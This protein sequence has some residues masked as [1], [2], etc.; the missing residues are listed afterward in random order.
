M[1][2]SSENIFVR[3]RIPSNKNWHTKLT[4]YYSRQ[5]VR[6]NMEIVVA[7]W[8]A[9]VQEILTTL[10]KGWKSSSLTKSNLPLRL[11]SFEWLSCHWSLAYIYP[12]QLR[13]ANLLQWGDWGLNMIRG[14]VVFVCL[15]KS[16]DQH[17]RDQATSSSSSTRLLS[18]SG[19]QAVSRRNSNSHSHSM[20]GGEEDRIG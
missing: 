10:R 11:K 18:C 1:T 7:F 14:W 4:W 3:I 20:V 9:K 2:Y 12:T 19:R 13:V 16:Q 8:R 17:F 5:E 15:L 6:W